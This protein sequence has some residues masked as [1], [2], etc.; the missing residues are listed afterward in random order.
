MALYAVSITKE[1]DWHGKREQ[2]DNTYYYEGPDAA[3]TEDG[4]RQFVNKIVAEEKGIHGVSAFFVKARLWSAGGT[5]EQNETLLLDDLTGQGT[6][7]GGLTFREAAILVEWECGRKNVKGK[8]V[9]LRKYIR[10]QNGVAGADGTQ[11][12][13]IDKIQPTAQARMRAYGNNVQTIEAPVGVNWQLISPSGRLPRFNN[14]AV[15][16]DYVISRE[17]RRN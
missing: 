16:N 11:M 17:F 8:K 9:Y 1:T 14:N 10:P 15:C 12:Q 7:L 5:K 3:P 13:G 4:L 2:F 6:Q